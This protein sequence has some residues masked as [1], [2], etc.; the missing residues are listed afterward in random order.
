MYRFVQ[1]SYELQID[2]PRP[3]HQRTQASD[4]SRCLSCRT[5]RQGVCHLKC[6]CAPAVRCVNRGP[7][8]LYQD[9]NYAA[10]AHRAAG[11]RHP[12]EAG[13]ELLSTQ[14]LLSYYSHTTQLLLNHYSATTHL[15]LSHYSATTHILLSHYSVTTQPQL[16]HYSATT[17]MLLTY[18][19]HTTHILLSHYSVTNQPLISH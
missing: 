11:Y 8:G 14:P 17:Y 10:P 3:V 7:R 5:R 9:A 2:Q 15:L 6:V 18:Y 16:S 1:V 13:T 12:L 4:R 19:S